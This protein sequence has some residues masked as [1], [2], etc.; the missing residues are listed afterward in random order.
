MKYQCK[1]CN[2]TW[3]GTSYTF[4]KVREHEKTHQGKIK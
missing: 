2:F 3:E 4:E 1:Y